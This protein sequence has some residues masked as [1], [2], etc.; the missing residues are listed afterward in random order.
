MTEEFLHHIWKF[1]LFNQ[2]DLQSTAGETI[3]IVKVGNHNSDAGPDFFNA[4]LRIGKTLWAGNVE[5]HINASDWK[6]HSHQ[7]D[8]AYD[9]IILHIVYNADE[10]IFRASGE[11]MPTV[12][13]KEKIE[14]KIYQNYL[15]FKSSNDWIP[16]EKQISKVP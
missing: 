12:E 6:K 14:K 8:K 9:N 4:Q 2:L 5:I 7:L 3:E 15:N 16:C 13:L 11:I 1:R 10:S